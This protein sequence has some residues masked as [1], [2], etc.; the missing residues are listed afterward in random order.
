MNKNNMNICVILSQRQR[1]DHHLSVKTEELFRSL[2]RW[3]DR[4]EGE[5]NI[6]E[7]E[8]CQWDFSHIV[9]NVQNP[10]M[11][12][13]K[14]IYRMHHIDEYKMFKMDQ[15]FEEFADS[16]ARSRLVS[17]SHRKVLQRF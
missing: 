15:G 2:I 1:D 3:V 11:K 6:P 16:E 5:L 13:M 14:N 7:N 12:I 17:S 8:I 9:Y 10:M 4:S